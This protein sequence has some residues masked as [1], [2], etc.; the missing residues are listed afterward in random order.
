MS[1]QADV[2]LHVAWKEV[3]DHARGRRFL[4]GAVMTTVLCL[5]AAV[6]RVGDFRQ[7]HQE[8][9]LFLQRWAPSVTEQ[10]ERDEVVQVENT[11]AVS[12]LSV[13]AVGL[14]PVVPFR[15]TSTKEGLRF[16][17]GRGAQNSIDALFGY[18]DVSFVVTTL[19][20]LLSI[21]LTFDSI[22]GER[23]DGTLA[24]MLSYPAERWTIVAAKIVGNAVVAALSLAPALVLAYVYT[25]ASGVGTMSVWHWLLYTAFAC[26]YALAF[27]AA[28]VAISARARRPV[29]AQ[30][31]A[32]FVWALA[33]FVL[34]RAVALGVNYVRPP[35]R[36]AELAIREDEQLSALRLA[37]NRRLEKAF[38]LYMSGDS[39][40]A[41]RRDEFDRARRESTDAL[42][43]ERRAVL[44][45]IWDEQRAD[46]EARERYTRLL[47][48]CS[49]AAVFQQAGAELAWTGAEQ[50]RHFVAEA[51]SYDES[52]GRRLA[53]SREFFYARE[54]ENRGRAL[55]V[56]EDVRAFMV[57][58]QPTWVSS[59][60]ILRRCVVPFSLMALF[61]L[62][63][64]AIALR[65][66]DRM[67]VRP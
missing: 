4:L 32:L 66:A 39:E 37:H 17:Q 45:K 59:D 61:A 27:V 26:L 42:R 19:L 14:E 7:A 58:F 10:L 15:F 11:R 9:N 35:L 43:K 30:L 54:T 40:A 41:S 53:E 13:L 51:R 47:A 57:P 25:L 36:A 18:L 63:A 21:A 24:L 12:P 1:G 62:V 49:P 8:R 44:G 6:I 50:R 67:D 46:E 23:A 38:L 3:R 64:F 52:I 33:V 65:A 31:S 56:H 34:P 2:F 16:G 22:C 29:D 60:T 5:L 55:V 48:V 20:S 28:G